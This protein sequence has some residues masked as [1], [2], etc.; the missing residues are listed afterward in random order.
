M[1]SLECVSDI[2]SSAGSGCW[3]FGSVLWWFRFFVFVRGIIDG[4]CF[5]S[6]DVLCLARLLFDHGPVFSSAAY[7]R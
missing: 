7:D 3:I 1:L 2:S 6:V 4:V 5:L